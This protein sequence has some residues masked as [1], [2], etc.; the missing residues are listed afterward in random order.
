MTIIRTGSLGSIIEEC[1][2]FHDDV[3][4]VLLTKIL[5]HP[6]VSRESR[7]VIEV[8]NAQV[9]GIIVLEAGYLL[10]FQ[11]AKDD[12]NS[13]VQQVYLRD[14]LLNLILKE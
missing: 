4:A 6:L 14:D 10:T 9:T 2:K 13:D 8:S 11:Y 5:R 1:A 7:C 12:G 3:T